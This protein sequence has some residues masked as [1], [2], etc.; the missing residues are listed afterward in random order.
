ML[1]IQ[2]MVDELKRDEGFK[3]L[4]YTCT[5]G[6]QTIGYGQNIEDNPIPEYIAEA[7][8]NHDIREIEERLCDFEWFAPMPDA[9]QRVIVNMAFNLGLNGML[10]FK[11]MIAAIKIGDYE[12]AGEEMINSRWYVQVGD[13][14]KR[15]VLMMKKGE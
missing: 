6:K 11:K 1:D 13:R 3:G 8:L 2:K 7:W 15:L 9:R 5:A 14:A 10:G 4:V 12:Q